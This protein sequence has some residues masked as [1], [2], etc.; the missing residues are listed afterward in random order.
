MLGV[1]QVEVSDMIDDPAVDLLGNI[2]IEASVAGLHM[3]DRDLQPLG[4]NPGNAAVC[5]PEDENSIGPLFLQDLFDL[6]ES[7]AQ[8]RPQRTG[9]DLQEIIRLSDLQIVE[10]DLVQFVI[11]VLAGVDNDMLDMP[12][13]EGHGPGET[14]NLRPCAQD[15]H[16]LQ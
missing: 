7:V 9:I 8:D 6:D 14:D 15:G 11:I 16:Y 10:E 13:E 1:D 2:G 3:K 12:V 5:V 4:H